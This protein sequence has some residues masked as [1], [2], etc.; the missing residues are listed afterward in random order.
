MSNPTIH[1][2]SFADLMRHEEEILKRIS[3]T[4]NGGHL[5]LAH[6]F[7]LFKDIGVVISEE[8]HYELLKMNPALFHIS[9]QAY[10]AIRGSKKP[11]P[12]KVRIQHL[13]HQKTEK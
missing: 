12:N 3:S 7:M 6:P 9:A 2:G 8:A 13:F 11:Q 4:N 10:R 5:F 1:V